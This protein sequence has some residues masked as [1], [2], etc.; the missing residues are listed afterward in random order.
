MVQVQYVG[1]GACSQPALGL[2]WAPDEIKAVHEEV[3]A[4]LLGN[5]ANPFIA[6]PSSEVQQ[7]RPAEEQTTDS[8]EEPDTEP[9]TGG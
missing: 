7:L 5:P 1:T 4:S 3:A 2:E 6:V 9:G 8:V